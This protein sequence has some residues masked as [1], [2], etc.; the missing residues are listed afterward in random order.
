MQLVASVAVLVIGLL[1]AFVLEAAA[2]LRIF[3]WLLIVVGLLGLAS[4]V[5][6]ARL[7]A[8]RDS[9]PPQR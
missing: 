3:G 6:L 1:I 7:Q 4:R 2:D 5:L 8:R 9:P